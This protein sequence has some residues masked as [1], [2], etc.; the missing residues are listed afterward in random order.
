MGRSYI[1]KTGLLVLVFVQTTFCFSQKPNIVLIVADDLGWTDL[2][3]YG[4][5]FYET[6]NLDQLAAKGM[7][8]TQAYAACNV[9]SPSRAAIM[10]GK[11]PARTHITDWI[12]G[13]QRPYARLLPPDWTM[14]LPLEETTI[15]E[16]LKSQGYATASIGKWHLGD[17]EKYYPEHQGF[18]VNIGG[19][20]KGSPTSYFSPYKNPR[21]K[22]GV[23]GE[24]LTDRLA[25]EAIQ[26][27]STTHNRP[28][29]VYLPFYAVHTPLKAKDEDLSYFKAKIDT[30]KNHQNPVY[31]GLIKN[32]DRN[33][34]KLINALQQL[35]LDK[36]TLV[37]FTSDNGGLIGNRQNREKQV[38]SNYPLREGK[39]TAYEGGTRV[40]A[41]FYWAEHIKPGST[42]T[43]I[44]SMDMFSTIAGVAGLHGK[45][46]PVNDG[47]DISPL[48]LKQEK[49]S[50]RNL[51]W[52][53]PHYHS[54]GATPY[55]AILEGDTKLIYY[56]ETGK[57]ELYNLKND[58]GE[59]HDLSD[60]EK[61]NTERL[62]LSL[63]KWLKE[64]NAQLPVINPNFDKKE[65]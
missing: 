17:D 62:Y 64:T 12:K 61:G 23:T 6:P 51:Y 31:A 45:D 63:Q 20:Y 25:D 19:Y 26:F 47:A 34:G 42:D 35:Q 3:C 4:S 29:F 38:T 14:Q 40:P 36:N 27:I 46:I 60:K 57:K 1:R 21:L 43:P 15:A 56:Y 49:L 50:N 24:Q 53:Y 28:F 11:Y 52:H 65:K 16:L 59:R 44:I 9:C 39:G 2:A 18:D 7:K 48:L 8:F 58:I 22:D 5:D 41:I 32:M 13:H 33:I 54:Q 55:S 37:I 10:T 30:S